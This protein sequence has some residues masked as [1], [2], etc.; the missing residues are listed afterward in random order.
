MA[1]REFTYEELIGEKPVSTPNAQKEFSYEELI[2]QKS[3]A[4]LR[5]SAAPK[6]ESMND[7]AAFGLYPTG[8][9]NAAP[10]ERK[11]R[12]EAK[13]KRAAEFLGFGAEEQPEF[14]I[15][16]IPVSGAVGAGISAAAPKALQYGGRALF[17][18][19]TP[20]TR[21]AGTAAQTL[22]KALGTT[23]L[24]PRIG[25]GAATGATADVFGQTAEQLGAP[26]IAGEA[27]AG[28]VPKVSRAVARGLVGE[29]TQTAE[30]IASK[31][32]SLG[33][34]LS[35]SQT[36]KVEPLPARGASFQDE[37]N[38]K[39][40][41]QLATKGTGKQVDEI[42]S[43][44]LLERLETLGGD[45]D[46]IY[47][48]KTFKV[49]PGIE[50]D[51]TSI[52]QKEQELGAAGVSTVKNI[53]DSIAG[54]IKTQGAVKSIEGDDLQRLRNALSEK[55]RASGSRINAF[56][57]NGLIDKIDDAVAKFNP[58]VKT[59]LNELRPKYRNAIILEDMYR[60]G[61]I[62]QGNISPEV[63]GNALRKDMSVIRKQN[64]AKDI[65]QLGEIGRELQLRALWQREG[66]RALSDSEKSLARVLSGPS[67]IVTS[68]LGLRTQQA[69]A[70]Q[71][72]M[73][74]TRPAA[75]KFAIPAGMAATEVARQVSQ[76]EE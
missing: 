76:P 6:V 11:R 40:F 61:G 49:D 3:S 60:A 75:A 50:N 39:I 2:G 32:E 22:G 72:E 53:A 14:D 62:R 37:S 56:E 73:G 36:R 31:A 47:K 52:I 17:M 44:F 46:K 7:G 54:K 71:K 20:I 8:K 13:A 26:R 43:G 55:A 15:G 48:G 1:D 57:I 29:A 67:D 41:N 34:K 16:R 28:M 65:D 35:P 19:P 12:I 23:S 45:F 70:L 9:F 25:V 24:A 59:Q 58:Q 64:I 63:L 18:I 42:D 69:R 38:Q 4:P 74:A 68:L 30:K 10:E 21:A 51:L 27:V 5:P 66:A 33:I